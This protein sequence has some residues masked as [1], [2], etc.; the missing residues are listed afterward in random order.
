MCISNAEREREKREVYLQRASG[1]VKG[2][3]EMALTALAA[4]LVPAQHSSYY[5]SYRYLSKKFPV[6]TGTF[7]LL[8]WGPCSVQRCPRGKHLCCWFQSKA[9]GLCTSH[10]LALGIL[11]LIHQ[12]TKFGFCLLDWNIEMGHLQRKRKNSSLFFKT[13]NFGIF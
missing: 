5:S 11:S 12:E 2:G 7:W 4:A 3:S 6:Q 8:C 9:L 13:K 10:R 1:D